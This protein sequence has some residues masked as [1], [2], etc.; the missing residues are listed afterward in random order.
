MPVKTRQI[1]HFT[2]M[3]DNEANTVH[4]VLINMLF[5]QNFSYSFETNAQVDTL[6]SYKNTDSF[7][8]IWN[9]DVQIQKHQIALFDEK[10]RPYFVDQYYFLDA[11]N[12][13]QIVYP[14][15]ESKLERFKI[16]EQLCDQAKIP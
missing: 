16:V 6:K 5:T 10:D 3:V 1:Q 2:H 4:F 13:V 7:Q 9:P 8:K 11:R 14:N 12:K 15:Y